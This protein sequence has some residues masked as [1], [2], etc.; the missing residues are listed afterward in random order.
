MYNLWNKSS[1]MKSGVKRYH[2]SNYFPSSFDE[3]MR[4]VERNR[5]YCVLN[6]ITA[7]DVLHLAAACGLNY[8]NLS[9]DDIAVYTSSGKLA[10]IYVSPGVK[11]EN[12]E[13]LDF[14]EEF[15]YLKI[16]VDPEIKKKYPREDFVCIDPDYA[17]KNADGK[18]I[19]FRNTRRGLH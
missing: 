16:I 5:S 15:K 3:L 10:Y 4:H 7:N 9:G 2:K 11:L 13:D 1:L 12:D 6:N 19:G 14:L 8:V 18:I 17:V